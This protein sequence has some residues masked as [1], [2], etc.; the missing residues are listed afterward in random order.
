[1][2]DNLDQSLN[3]EEQTLEDDPPNAEGVDV[4]SLR[5]S[6][7][8]Q[9]LRSEVCAE[10]MFHVEI[11]SFASTDGPRAVTQAPCRRRNEERPNHS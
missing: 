3:H 9:K 5:R 11:L 10:P 7:R 8:E 1:L 4:E 2:E 6:L